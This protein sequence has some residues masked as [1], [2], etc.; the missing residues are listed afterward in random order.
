MQLMPAGTI[1]TPGFVTKLGMSHGLLPIRVEYPTDGETWERRLVV[2]DNAGT[3]AVESVITFTRTDTGLD[4]VLS[5]DPFNRTSANGWTL[6]QAT[7]KN[8]WLDPVTM[9]VDYVFV[10]SPVSVLIEDEEGRR[11]GVA[12]RRVFGDLPDVLP[13]IGAEQLYL[14]PL[15]RKLRV[16]LSGTGEGTYTLGIVSGSLGRSVTL[17]G[18]PVT[19]DTR[20]TVEIADGLREVTVSSTDPEKTATLHYGVA[21]VRQARALRVAGVRMSRRHRLRLRSVDGLARFELRADGPRHRVGFALASAGRTDVRR[22]RVPDVEL[23]DERT[24]TFQVADWAALGPGSVRPV[25]E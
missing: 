5:P 25:E 2:Y 18:V 8:N 15:D 12:G 23:G 13:A 1:L 20:D 11:F 16:S 17:T 10:L 22:E 19:P 6:S 7:L 9:P 3:V 4:F 21:G 24:R 14:L